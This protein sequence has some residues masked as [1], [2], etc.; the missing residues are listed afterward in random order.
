[1]NTKVAP[2]LLS[3]DLFHLE[4]EIDSIRGCDY[5]HV[6][7]MDGDFVPNITYGPGF[8][9]ALAGTKIPQDVHLMISHPARHV[10]AFMDAG[11]AILT[12]HA[13]ADVHLHR[14][15]THIRKRGIKAGVSLNP[16][17]P[18]TMI[19]HVLSTVDLVL[20]M[21]VNPGFGGQK[22][23]SAML[24]KIRACRKMLDEAGCMDV[25]LE[26]DGGID[27]HT[28]PK[29]VDAGAALLVSGSALFT[30]PDRAGFIRQLQDLGS[31]TG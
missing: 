30:A 6:D 29:V 10:D 3:A 1:M 20:I 8:V 9:R 14:T 11:A 2:S 18:L 31:A 22:F 12:I 23:I 7:V 28:A 15:L 27:L 4:R 17:T 16:S 24:S 21:T 26:V 13:E 5:L 25:I 19:E